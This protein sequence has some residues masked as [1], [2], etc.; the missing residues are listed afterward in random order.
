MCSVYLL[1]DSS[2]TIEL[3]FKFFSRRYIM[4]AAFLLAKYA[5]NKPGKLG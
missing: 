4:A 5:F 1:K 3:L 2:C